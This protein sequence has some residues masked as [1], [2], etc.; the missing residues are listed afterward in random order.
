[1]ECLV[2]PRCIGFVP[3]V[4]EL[5][6]S[7]SARVTHSSTHYGGP[8]TNDW[9]QD[10]FADDASRTQDLLRRTDALLVDTPFRFPTVCRASLG[11][12]VRLQ[13]SMFVGM[14][15]QA[16]RKMGYSGGGVR[17]ENPGKCRKRVNDTAPLTCNQNNNNNNNVLLLLPVISLAHTYYLL[18]FASIETLGCV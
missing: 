3:V 8:T 17:S 12:C 7:S 18:F 11:C 16:S 10:L 2:S 1:M 9:K 15:L 13:L 6:A 5:W 4:T 14:V